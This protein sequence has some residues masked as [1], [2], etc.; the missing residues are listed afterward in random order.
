[1]VHVFCSD[2]HSFQRKISQT[3]AH[4]NGDMLKPLKKNVFIVCNPYVQSFASLVYN[5]TTDITF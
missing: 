1:M 4:L 3:G 5:V 2:N